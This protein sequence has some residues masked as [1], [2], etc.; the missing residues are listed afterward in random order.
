[1]P[2]FLASALKFARGGF[3]VFPVAA[4]GKAPLTENGLKDAT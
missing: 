1:M 3:P 4:R 2:N